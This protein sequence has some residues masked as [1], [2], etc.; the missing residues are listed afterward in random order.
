MGKYNLRNGCKNRE[1]L[2]KYLQNSPSRM[3]DLEHARDNVDNCSCP[4][5]P[6]ADSDLPKPIYIAGLGVLAGTTGILAVATAAE[7]AAGK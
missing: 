6:C 7:I 5:C 2:V 3:H 4:S 1:D